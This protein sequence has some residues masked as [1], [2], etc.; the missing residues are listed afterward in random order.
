MSKEATARAR[1]STESL[2]GK[3]AKFFADAAPVRIPVQ[4][5]RVSGQGTPISESTVIEFGTP[6]EVLFTSELPLEFADMLH[7]Q[8]SDGTLDTDACVVALQYNGGRTAVAA[9]FT[10]NIANWIVKSYV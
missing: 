4:L 6:R 3:L 2:T 1:S 7:L 8:N 10:Q 5:T 9:R